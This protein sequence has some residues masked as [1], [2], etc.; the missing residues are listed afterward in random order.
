ML[1]VALVGMAVAVVAAVLLAVVF[2][3]LRLR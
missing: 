1:L 3:V 2:C